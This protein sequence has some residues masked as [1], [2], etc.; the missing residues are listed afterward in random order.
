MWQ[1]ETNNKLFL[2][3][4]VGIFMGALDLT[5]LVPALPAIGDSLNVTPAAVA[6]AL[7]IYAVFYAA[8]I[9]L[10][11]KLADLRGYKRIYLVSLGLFAGG[12]ALA[13]LAP[14][15]PTLTFARAVQAVGG[16]GI[17]PI[18]QAIVGTNLPEK[19]RGKLF[20]ILMGVFAVGAV[21]GPNLGGFFVRYVSWRW[22]FWI[23]VPLGLLGAL[24][25]KNQYLPAGNQQTY[26]D[27]PGAGLV[28]LVFS[29]LVLGVEGLRH[30][31]E[32]DFFSLRIAGLFVLTLV[33]AVLLVA[34]ERKSK[35]P[36][37]D[38]SLITSSAI[39]PLLIISL[40]VGYTLLGG[41]VFTPLYAQLTFQTSAFAAGAMLNAAAAGVGVSSWL[42]GKYTDQT[43][44][45]PLIIIGL[46]LLTV[47]LLEMLFLSSY[48]WGILS[49]LFFIGGGLG[50][51]QG[52][53]SYIALA[54][55]PKDDQGQVAGLLSITRSMG[56]AL[57][58][59]LSSFLLS[60]TSRSLSS[61]ENGSSLATEVWGSRSSLQA[62]TQASETVQQTIRHTIQSGVIKGWYIA[63]AAAALGLF[64]AFFTKN[65]PLNEP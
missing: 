46:F 45:K 52:P 8:S 36:I 41:I 3:L 13:A 16:G 57:G 65:G 63:L 24:L 61:F 2:S 7:S 28:A 10:I 29:S 59:S 55:A 30:L 11:S 47:G 6:L 50:F 44:G 64:V 12:S 25:F 20:S 15:L 62:L 14:N 38:L 32:Q 42:T 1:I 23:Q 34:V 60:R 9:P 58:I 39:A 43:G 49:G 27:W 35:D 18:A 56:G 26:I 5:I 40:L 4:G 17:F 53:L 31:G 21:L 54:Q 37:L 22:I 33:G 19:K 51:S 48:L